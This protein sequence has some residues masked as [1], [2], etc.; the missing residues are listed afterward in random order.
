M[1]GVSIVGGGGQ[2]GAWEVTWDLLGVLLALLIQ[3][4]ESPRSSKA[5]SHV[6]GDSG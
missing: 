5:A 1:A 4:E 3:T 2:G 6:W